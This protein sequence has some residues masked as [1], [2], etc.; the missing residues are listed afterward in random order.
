MG[1]FGKNKETDFIEIQPG[2]AEHLR[3]ALK[4]HGTMLNDHILFEDDPTVPNDSKI[5]VSDLL[6]HK[7]N[8]IHA[9][10][11][12]IGEAYVKRIDAKIELTP[13]DLIITMKL[14]ISYMGEGPGGEFEV[15]IKGNLHKTI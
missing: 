10:G 4:N 5:T 8:T 6:F 9:N 3:L 13:N 15:T 14:L 1:F 2:F 7:K 12:K 11:R